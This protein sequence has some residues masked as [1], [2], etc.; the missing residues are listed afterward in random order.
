LK[1]VL[2]VGASKGQQFKFGHQWIGLILFL[3]LMIQGGLGWYHHK[4]YVEDKP[5]NRR[6]FTHLHLWFGRVLLFLGLI[7][8]G[9]GMQLYGDNAGAQAGWYLI[10]I[11]IV[12]AYAFFYWHN[13]YRNKKRIN[14]S[15]DP[16]PFEDPT[17]E[18]APSTKNYRPVNPAAAMSD[19]DLGT[20]QSE[21]YDPET[22]G[23]NEYGVRIKNTKAPA[24][25]MTAIHRPPTTAA[26]AATAGR[27]YDIVPTALIPGP[28]RTTEP[29]RTGGTVHIDPQID[30]FLDPPRP[31]TGGPRPQTGRPK[32]G[33]P[34]TVAMVGNEE[35]P[36]QTSP[37]VYSNTGYTAPA[38]TAAYANT[39]YSS[40]NTTY[41]TTQNTTYSTAQNTG[42]H[43]TQDS[44]YATHNSGYTAQNPGYD[45]QHPGYTTQHSGYTTTQNTAYNTTPNAAYTTASN[46]GYST[47]PNTGYGTA[48]STPV[49]SAAAY[50]SPMRCTDIR[51]DPMQYRG[52]DV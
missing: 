16:T 34:Y 8:M 49:H 31:K 47:A 12:S 38:Y 41:P 23:V 5:T 13:F 2:T 22:S 43:T 10:T 17:D 19:N 3:G 29:L 30:P 26:P 39:G 28:Y 35:A 25:S 9:L 52:R 36:V 33:V 1:V 37:A 7:N 24:P 51:Y 48:P 27:R 44:E 20:Y 18:D 50:N 6:W 14:D 32:T 4:R 45:T 40:Q 42:Y 46:P 15:F 21:H 11:A